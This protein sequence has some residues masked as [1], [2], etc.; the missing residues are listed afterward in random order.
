MLT[1]SILGLRPKECFNALESN[2]DLE[3]KIIFIPG[4]DNKQD[5]SVWHFVSFCLKVGKINKSLYAVKFMRQALPYITQEPGIGGKIKEKQEYFQ[6]IEIP[7]YEPSGEGNHLYINFTKS[8]KTTHEV[9]DSIARVLNLDKN[10]VGVAGL[11]DK[12]ALT[13][14]TMSINLEGNTLDES[15]TTEAFESLGVKVNWTKKHVN[16]LKPGHL[17]GNKFIVTITSLQN[18]G[19][20]FEQAKKIAEKLRKTGIPNFYGE[21]RFGIDGDNKEKAEKILGG[22]LKIRDRWLLKLL[23]S[24]YQSYLFNEYLVKRVEFGFDKLIK[25]D[26]C[27]KHDTGGLF[28]VENLEAEQKRYDNHEISFTVP[29]FGKKLWFAADESGEFEKKILAESKLSDEQ[30]GK[31]G[32]GLRRVGRILLTDL[33]LKKVSDGIE[34]SFTLPKGS[35]ATVVIREFTKND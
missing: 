14:Q 29:M 35:F 19:E 18:I 11:K 26:I 20:A 33:D 1:A 7:A 25:G 28:I 2:I 13:T 21:Q 30:L 16:K 27:K 6:V 34:V 17:K 3:K 15:K 9:V 4:S 31:L 10:S 8:G 22:E 5:A 23:M 24:S 12:H 32:E